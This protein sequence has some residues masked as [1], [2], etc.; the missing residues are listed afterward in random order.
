M[1]YCYQQGES[2]K[3]DISNTDIPT[4]AVGI[5]SLGQAGFVIKGAT[6]SEYIVVDPYLTRSIEAEDP[7]TEFVREYDPPLEPTALA[8]AAAILISHHHD[9]HLDL[10]TLRKLQHVASNAAPMPPVVVPAAH[11]HIIAHLNHHTVLG[12]ISGQKFQIGRFICEAVASAHTE[13]TYDD[14]GQDLYLGYFITVDGVRIYFSGDTV[15]TP[16]LLESVAA[17]RP[18]IAMLPINGQ[19]VFRTARNIIGNMSGREAV[20]FCSAV[21]ADLFIPFHYDMFPNNRDN[22]A[23]TVDYLFHHHRNQK[24]H[25]FAVGERFIY[26]P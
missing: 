1:K 2:L 6:S 8:D 12:V 11:E 10:A 13:Y 19:D 17:F 14:K 25:M 15:V 16:Q 20:D 4:G 18:H 21:G 5:W 7:G 9:D 26:L 22:P 24:F 23:H 3:R